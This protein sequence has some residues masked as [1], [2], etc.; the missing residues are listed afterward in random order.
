MRDVTRL[1]IWQR[2]VELSSQITKAI[3][4][5]AGR[6]SPGLR[7]QAIRAASGIAEAIAEGCGKSSD[8]ELARFVDIACGSATELQTQLVLAH[9]HGV[10]RAP[11][12]KKFWQECSELRRMMM[13]FERKVRERAERKDDEGR[14]IIR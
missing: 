1:I 6:K 8:W 3:P 11:Q 5:A 2:A 9:R 13:A 14:R 7:R 10:L 12:F 4:I